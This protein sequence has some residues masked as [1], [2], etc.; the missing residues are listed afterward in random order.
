MSITV[1]ATNFWGSA[2]PSPDKPALQGATPRLRLRAR[3][4]WKFGP[5]AIPDSYWDAQLFRL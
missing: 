1:Y 5:N 2:S 3:Y 4:H